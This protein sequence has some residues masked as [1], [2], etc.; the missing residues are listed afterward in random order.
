MTL[1]HLLNTMIMSTMILPPLLIRQIRAGGEESIVDIEGV[2]LI[3]VLID[4]ANT[5]QGAGGIGRG[6][7]R[8]KVAKWRFCRIG[9]IG[10]GD[11]LMVLGMEDCLAEVEEKKVR[12]W[13][14]L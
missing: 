14:V 8:A 2:T 12:W 1:S 9:L 13:S 10:M 11:R 6:A 5:V 3:Q 4:R 7:Q